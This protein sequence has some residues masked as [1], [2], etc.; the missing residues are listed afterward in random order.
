MLVTKRALLASGA[1]VA[2]AST[3]HAQGQPQGSNQMEDVI[4]DHQAVHL[5]PEGRIRI[6]KMNPAGHA[7]V[8]AHGTEVTGHSMFYRANGKNYVMHDKKMPDGTMLFDKANEWH[9]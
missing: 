9:G 1:T 7:A 2:F 6:M 4:L 3:L 5:A 8:M